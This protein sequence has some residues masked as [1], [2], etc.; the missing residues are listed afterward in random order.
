MART[1]RDARIETRTARSRLAASRKPYWRT[2]DPGLHVGYYKGS[3][4]GRWVLRLYA[5]DRRYIEETIGTSDDTS[6]ADGVSVLDYRQALAAA[7]ARATEVSAAAKGKPL[8]PYTVDNACDDY[9]KE[10]IDPHGQGSGPRET[11]RMLAREIRPALGGK[12]ISDLTSGDIR[13]W[14]NQIASRPPLSRSGKALPVDIADPEVKRRRQDSANR[15]LRT[16]KAV[17]NHAYGEGRVANDGEWRRVK[18]FKATSEAR[19][20]WLSLDEAR[21]LMNACRPDF[22]AL[23]RGALLTGARP[24]DLKRLRVG[25]FHGD[26]GSIGMANRKAGKPYSCH[27]SEE[28]VKFFQGITAGRQPDE[29]IFTRADGGPWADDDHQRPMSKASQAARLDPPATFYCLRHTYCSHAIMSGVPM[30]VVAQNVGHAD[31]RMLEKHYG[32]LSPSYRADAIRA[33]VPNWGGDDDTNV[34]PIG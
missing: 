12:K 1:L 26:S 33:G 29:Y 13:D 18:A 30:L 24:G 2:V 14:L 7:R 22:R 3:R 31:T 8:G 28:G 17:L 32:H 19:V 9:E 11:R 20:R 27:L 6:D 4:G 16:L 25:N 15:V 21:R 10:Q 34:V 5:G 23:V